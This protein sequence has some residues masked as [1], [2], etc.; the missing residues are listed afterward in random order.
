M[1]AWIGMLIVDMVRYQTLFRYALMLALS[2]KMS[3]LK[4][5][6]KVLGLSSWKVQFA[7][8]ESHMIIQSFV[9]TQTG[10]AKSLIFY[11]DK[12]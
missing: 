8:R 3:K 10:P 6:T 1:V 7:F 5:D 12:Y 11:V 2:E 4:N 9:L